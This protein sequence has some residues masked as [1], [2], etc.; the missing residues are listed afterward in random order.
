MANDILFINSLGIDTIRFII[1]YETLVKW[2][3]KNSLI[4]QDKI[5]NVVINEFYQKEVKNKKDFEI[6]AIKIS[7]TNNLSG[8]A[9]I[10]INYKSRN[11]SKSSKKRKNW[12]VEVVFAGLRQPTKNMKK[13]TYEILSKFVKRFKV[14]SID[15]CVDGLSNISIDKEN[16][17]ELYHIFKDY[18]NTISDMFFYKSSLYIN[19]PLSN[20][21]DTDVF[22]KIL[23]YDKYIK[24]IKINK[25]ISNSLINW[26]RV[27]FTIDFK[28]TKLDE[29][30]FDDYIY[31]IKKIATKYFN[32]MKFDTSYLFDKQLAPLVNGHKLRYLK[33]L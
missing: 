20:I 13:E 30:S 32:V 15:I 7:S 5:N 25:N 18:L 24:E 29:I 16:E 9:I 19:K 14:S 12:F 10:K 2:L 8:Y 33:N 1:S 17:Y 23:V 31:D 28:N 27:E 22:K 6:K 11:L 21:N 26:K 3:D 4:I